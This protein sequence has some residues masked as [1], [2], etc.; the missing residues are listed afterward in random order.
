MPRS[1]K[2]PSQSPCKTSRIIPHEGTVTRRQRIE[3][4]HRHI[5]VRGILK[6]SEKMLTPGN[7]SA[8]GRRRQGTRQA[9][10][11]RSGRDPRQGETFL[12]I[13]NSEEKIDK[14]KVK[15]GPLDPDDKSQR[16]IEEGLGR[17]V[18]RRRTA[19]RAAR[20]SRSM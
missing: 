17:R 4:K 13:V 7:S 11:S 18:G 2:F 16:V 15:I 9:P 19:A 20:T 1:R 14:R 3:R 8:S 5:K 6:N 10:R 12:L